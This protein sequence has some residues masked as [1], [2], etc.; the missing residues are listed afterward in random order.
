MG[1]VGLFLFLLSSSWEGVISRFIFQP[2]D[3]L[4]I[5]ISTLV[6]KQKLR[7]TQKGQ[8]VKTKIKYQAKTNLGYTLK[9]KFLMCFVKNQTG[10]LHVVFMLVTSQI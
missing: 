1:F 8:H 9:R 10:L 4:S 5:I 6:T 3:N 7:F 2:S